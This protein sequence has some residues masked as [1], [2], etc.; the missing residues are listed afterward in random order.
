MSL[1]PSIEDLRKLGHHA[2]NYNWGIQTKVKVMK[3]QLPSPFNVTYEG[4]FICT[5][6]GIIGTDKESQDAYKKG[7]IP[8]IL[9]KLSEIAESNGRNETISAEDIRFEE[10][11]ED[12]DFE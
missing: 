9:K 12:I 11:S 4:E 7:R 5:D 2:T 10:S 8:V 3:N 6:I 1:R